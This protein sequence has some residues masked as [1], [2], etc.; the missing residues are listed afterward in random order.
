MVTDPVR[1]RGLQDHV[2]LHT[3]PHTTPRALRVQWN[4]QKLSVESPMKTLFPTPLSCLL[5]VQRLK[6]PDDGA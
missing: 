3:H 1:N 6:A 2:C 5:L 4:F